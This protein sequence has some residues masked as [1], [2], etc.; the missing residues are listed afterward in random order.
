[1]I[2]F[3]SINQNKVQ[4]LTVYQNYIG[5]SSEISFFEMLYN[6]IL[7]RPKTKALRTTSVLQNAGW[8]R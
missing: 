1:M 2:Q 5:L 3:S 7:P 6:I 4:Q 8:T